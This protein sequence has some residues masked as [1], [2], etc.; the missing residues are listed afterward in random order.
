MTLLASHG[1]QHRLL[2]LEVRGSWRDCVE[3]IV[4]SL[5]LDGKVFRIGIR[6]LEDGLSLVVFE[7]EFCLID[8][9][10]EESEWVLQHSG[11]ELSQ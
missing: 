2:G 3:S 7:A 5:D 11:Q 1:N 9:I 4:G 6:N 8:S 10:R